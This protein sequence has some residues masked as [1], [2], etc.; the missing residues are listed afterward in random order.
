M[1]KVSISSIASQ[2]IN[3]ELVW[4]I[5]ASNP[6]VDCFTWFNP[7]IMEFDHL[8]QFDKTINISKAIYKHGFDYL[9]NEIMKCDLVCANCHRERTYNRLIDSYELDLNRSQPFVTQQHSTLVNI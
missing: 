4:S 8:P 2:Q 9:I 7:W 1:S 3:K 6:C 5:K